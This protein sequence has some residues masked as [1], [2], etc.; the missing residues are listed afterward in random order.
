MFLGLYNNFVDSVED[1]T[2]QEPWRNLAHFLNGI[3][4]PPSLS[5]CLAWTKAL[6]H[7]I[8]P[9]HQQGL[10]YGHLLPHLVSFQ[11][12]DHQRFA[13]QLGLSPVP[14]EQCTLAPFSQ[15]FLAPEVCHQHATLR[16]DVYS[17]AAFFYALLF[18]GP[19]GQPLQILGANTNQ[20]ASL[21]PITQVLHKALSDEPNHRYPDLERWLQALDLAEQPTQTHNQSSPNIDSLLDLPST[22]DAKNEWSSSPARHLESQTH[23]RS[24][25]W[26]AL[27]LLL[28]LLFGTILWFLLP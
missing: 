4:T 20:Q 3:T 9:A 23:A 14:P 18:G 2:T 10:V 6:S 25:R 7:T 12:Q 13:I 22:T 24:S 26:I 1:S 27:S 16:T 19:P 5:W 8:A 15:P 11:I 17:V 28:L 21:E